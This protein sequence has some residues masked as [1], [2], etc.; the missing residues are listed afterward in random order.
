ML[1]IP[2]KGLKASTGT[3]LPLLALLSFPLLAQNAQRQ[4]T[5]P[6]WTILDQEQDTA[7]WLRMPADLKRVPPQR[8]DLERLIIA[9]D[10]SWSPDWKQAAFELKNLIVTI[11]TQGPRVRVGLKASAAQAASLL[12]N[13]LAPYIDGYLYTDSPYIPEGDPTG[14]LWLETSAEETKVLSTLVDASSIG[15]TA[16][17]FTDTRLSQAH[18]T[19]LETIAGTATGSLDIQPE[20]AG[21][22]Q[23]RVLFFFDPPTGNY[24]LAVYP[25]KD[26]DTLVLF[27]LAEGVRVTALYPE[28]PPFRAQQFGRRTELRLDGKTPYL[29]FLLEPGERSG[30]TE[31]LEI[32]ERETIDPYELVVKNQVFKDA[33]AQ[34]LRS[35]MV[36]ESQ[37]YRYQT[38]GGIGID[39]TYEDTVYVR[40][41]KPV[42]R[43]R[44]ELYLGGVKWTRKKQ[45][46]L[47][48]IEPEKVQSQPLLIDLDRSY[49]YTY[50]GEDLIGGAKTWRVRFEPTEPGD[51]FSGT[52]W[53]DQETGAHRRI[54]AIQSGLEAPV[55]GNEITVSYD[56]VEDNGTRYW[57]QVREQNLQ[58]ITIAGLRLALQ[59]DSRRSNFRF[60]RDEM[61][62]NLATAYQSD[63]VILR[64]TDKGFRYLSKKGDKREVSESTFGKKK[65]LLGGIFYEP[66]NDTTAPLA[67]FNYTNLDFLGRGW[68]ANFFVAG[69]VNDLIVSDPDFLGRGWDLT[70]ELFLSAIKFSDS[71][72]ENGEEREDLELQELR[73]SL[74]LTLGIPLNTFFKL[75]FNYSL[76]YLDYS[77]GD[78][79]DE[80]YVIPVSTFENIGR[81]NLQFSRH[82][83]TTALQ[84]EF[85]QRGDWEEFGFPDDPEPLEDT[86]STLTFNASLSQRVAK[87]QTF[88][89]DLRYLK[90]W[91][92]DRLSRF[93]FG[94]FGNSVSGFGSSGAEGDQAAR[95]RLEYDIGIQGLFSIDF[96][97]D[98]AR[99][100]LDDN[101]VLALGSEED[102]VDLAGVGVAANFLGPWG[103]LIR[104][105]IGY[106]IHSDLEGEEGDI[107]GQ[108]VFL[109][110]F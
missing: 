84:Y 82:R 92:Q 2:R 88:G 100:W 7:L 48:L 60:N 38:P 29:F 43:V 24:H 58:V 69:A 39:V 95:I 35:L 97:L 55:I 64:D 15:V 23:D 8:K 10:P 31:S 73:E 71:I 20:V 110:L 28:N 37:N 5:L 33:E 76:R 94:F 30:T 56:W 75:D 61:E 66:T 109:K 98:A 63:A 3:L 96:Q 22:A 12:A 59:I 102:Y 53:I 42:E 34:K 68:Q 44:R 93:G 74:N 72:F 11:K 40:P 57:T 1:G 99:A 90:G 19:F 106:G 107:A 85:V 49:R 91:N 70:A 101:R 79:L 45:P 103:V 65:A 17:I 108:I 105:D 54:R 27:S 18:R 67:G 32:V 52:V 89:V 46:E 14:K 6:E 9:L 77:E 87:F 50:G 25:P 26:R 78:D 36:D 51:F 41:G 81:I 13:E 83:F 86:Y 80:D 62:N 104:A 4:G 16:V 47:P 21:I